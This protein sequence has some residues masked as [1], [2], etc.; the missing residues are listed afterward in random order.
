[1]ALHNITFAFGG[2]ELIGITAA[3]KLLPKNSS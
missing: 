1:M 3:V 2:L